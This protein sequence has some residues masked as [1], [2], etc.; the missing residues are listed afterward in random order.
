MWVCVTI[1][2][3]LSVCECARI[4]HHQ[5]GRIPSPSLCLHVV[6]LIGIFHFDLVL[7]VFVFFPVY[8]LPL[9]KKQNFNPFRIII[10]RVLSCTR[11]C[12]SRSSINH[13][14][15][16]TVLNDHQDVFGNLL[17]SFRSREARFLL[18]VTHYDGHTRPDP[19]RYPRIRRDLVAKEQRR[20][21]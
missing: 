13:C 20:S 14:D 7:F 18:V 16:G 9:L 15:H 6:R 19:C 4:D 12:R 3:L 17:R 5:F 2:L 8:P 1:I 11:R 10:A 21:P